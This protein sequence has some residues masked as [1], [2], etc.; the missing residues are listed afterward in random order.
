MRRQG[1][2]GALPRAAP[3][4]CSPGPGN[5]LLKKTWPPLE[6]SSGCSAEQRSA[7]VGK[8][9]AAAALIG[10]AARTDE[11]NE[12]PE[13]AISRAAGILDRRAERPEKNHVADDVQP[14]AKQEHGSEQR[15]GREASETGTTAMALLMLDTDISSYVIRRRPA[16]AAER[17]EH[18][19]SELRFGRHGG[20]AR[21][22]VG[23]EAA[24]NQQ[25]MM[26]KRASYPN[27]THRHDLGPDSQL[28]LTGQRCLSKGSRTMQGCSSLVPPYG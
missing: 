7:H 16:S 22:H 14:A 12:E 3:T 20:G 11:L 6:Q 1:T 25:L 4:R 27:C 28:Q 21:L 26:L 2:R 17:L 10:Y 24:Y 13:A 9:G 23:Q 18:H 15:G 5:G 8:A 19:A